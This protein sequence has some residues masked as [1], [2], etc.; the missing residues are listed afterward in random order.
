MNLVADSSEAAAR[1]LRAVMQGK[2]VLRGDD[3]YERVRQIWNGAVNYQPALFALCE[4]P[5]D[6]REAVL[7]ARIHRLPLSVRGGGHDWAGRALRQDGLVIDLSA[8]RQVVVDTEAQA[9]AVD[10]GAT[11]GEVIAAAA[12]HGL[13]AAV[14]TVGSVGMAGF[15]LGGGYGPL[16]PRYG[17][18]LDNL[19]SAQ[20]VLADGRLVTA[21]DSENPDLFWALRG[22]GGN[23]GVVT[24][25][26]IRLHPIRTLLSGLILFPWSEAEWVLRGYAEALASAPDE[27]AVIAGVLSAPDGSPVVFLAPTWSGETKQGEGIV[28]RLKRLGTPLLAQV[29]PMAYGD[30]LRMF[31]AH[32]VNGR[33]Y[34]VQT[35]WLPKLTLDSISTLISAGNTRTS[36]FTAI[37]LHHFHGAA[38]RVPLSTTA[39]GLRQAH[40]LVEVIA[41][42]EPST[43]DNS[44]VHQQWARTVSRALAT[45]ALPGGYAN[46][47]GPDEHEQIASAYGGNLSRLQRAKQRFDPNGLFTSAIPLPAGTAT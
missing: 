43:D 19:L 21:D 2:V 1:E 35:R 18:G 16:T 37:A 25:M 33:H 7:T 6:V 17:L 34:A 27:L 20:V 47:L 46:L 40:F 13:T 28:A 22:G 15:T 31:D 8:M 32:V 10:G 3:A 29:S 45:E 14:G 44:A 39:F 42:W 26:R 41:A 9:A 12:P 38:T 4:T 5:K 30:M 36:P 23:F 11:A 24:S